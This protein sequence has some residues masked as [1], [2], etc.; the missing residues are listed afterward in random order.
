MDSMNEFVLE[1][2]K[3]QKTIS[4]TFPSNSEWAGKIRKFA[5]NDPDVVVLSDANGALFAHIPLKYLN[6][7]KPIA[8]S[9]EQK[10]AATERLAKAREAKS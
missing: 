1:W 8:L 9:E 6:L 2:I 7:R 4:V 5:Q 3:G 10:Q